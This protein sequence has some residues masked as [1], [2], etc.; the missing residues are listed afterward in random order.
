MDETLKTVTIILSIGTVV[1]PVLFGYVIFNM[2]KVFASKASFEEFKA[3][4]RASLA[5]IQDDVKE[6]MRHPRG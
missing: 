1:G 2:S 6:I 5:T 4:T 3:E